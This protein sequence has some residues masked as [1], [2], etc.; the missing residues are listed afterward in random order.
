MGE[1]LQISKADGA[2]ENSAA[3]PKDISVSVII[4]SFNHAAF[5]EQAIKSVWAQDHAA[6]QIH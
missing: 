1:D 5:V 3:T 6:F 2:D 4:P